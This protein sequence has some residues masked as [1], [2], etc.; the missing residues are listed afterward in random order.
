MPTRWDAVTFASL[1]RQHTPRLYGL[2]LRL[3]GGRVADAEDLVHACWL[4]AATARRPFSGRSRLS[5]WLCGILVNC[6]R[7]TRRRQEGEPAAD[8]QWVPAPCT[9]D[10]LDA[11]QLVAA[12]PPAWREVVVLH[13][14]YGYTHEEI[15]DL[16]TIAAG[17]SKSRLARAHA[18][19]RQTFAREET[20]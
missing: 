14:L 1:Y 3:A 4:R 18:W 10:R 11:E 7:E 17:T 6:Y 8:E 9:E 12:L 2:A 13:D 20:P 5:T 19:L 16:L 15:A